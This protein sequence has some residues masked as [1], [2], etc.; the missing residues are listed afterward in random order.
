[1]LAGAE[2]GGQPETAVSQKN[3]ATPATAGARTSNPRKSVTLITAAEAKTGDR[4]GS[5]TSR[6]Q[7]VTPLRTGVGIEGQ[8]RRITL[9]GAG[10]GG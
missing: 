7:D 9:A 3:D 10:V 2:T 6:E 8:G 4:R 5:K 1:M